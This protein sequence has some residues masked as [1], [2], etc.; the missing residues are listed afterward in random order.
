MPVLLEQRSSIRI[1]ILQCLSPESSCTSLIKTFAIEKVLTNEPLIAAWN[2]PSGHLV[3]KKAVICG[4]REALIQLCELGYVPSTY[5]D[6]ML[7]LAHPNSAAILIAHSKATAE[8]LVF[9][10]S[11]RESSHYPMIEAIM[12]RQHSIAIGDALLKEFAFW[13]LQ[14]FPW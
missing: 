14:K 12:R 5:Q 1:Q 9:Q 4:N 6:L 7:I 10:I 11:H 8:Q 3:I 2:T 13:K